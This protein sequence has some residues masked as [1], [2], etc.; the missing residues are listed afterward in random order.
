[1]GRTGPLTALARAAGGEP[2]AFA[3]FYDEHGRDLVRF[4]APRL[5]DA[6]AALDLTAETFAQALR[7][8]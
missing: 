4:F 1:M 8:L 7:R 2:E 5:I 6:E 3:V